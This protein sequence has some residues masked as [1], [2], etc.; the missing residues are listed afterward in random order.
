MFNFDGLHFFLHDMN[1][2]LQLMAAQSFSWHGKNHIIV[3]DELFE[4]QLCFI[5]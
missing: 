4:K 5:Q 1:L 3:L 2:D